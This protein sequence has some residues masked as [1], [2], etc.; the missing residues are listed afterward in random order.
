MSDPP[1]HP[2]IRRRHS[3][4]T[5]STCDTPAPPYAL[6]DAYEN[7]FHSYD[8]EV[9]TYIDA[10]AHILQSFRPDTAISWG[11]SR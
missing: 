11:L 9:D 2:T 7:I 5:V 3:T 4:D 8:G 1:P 6:I 10:L